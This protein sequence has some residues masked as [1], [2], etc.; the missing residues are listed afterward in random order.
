MPPDYSGGAYIKHGYKLL[1]IEFLK[2][3]SRS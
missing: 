1:L 2:V 3:K